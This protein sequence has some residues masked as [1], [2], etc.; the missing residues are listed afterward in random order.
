MW[1]LHK[2]G[3]LDDIMHLW[4]WGAQAALGCSAEKRGSVID[5]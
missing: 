2:G 5:G 4:V 3:T 1:G